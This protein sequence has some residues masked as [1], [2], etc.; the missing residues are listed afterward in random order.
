[1]SIA[2]EGL[3]ELRWTHRSG[4]A[5]VVAGGIRLTAA[6]GT[7]WSNDAAGDGNPVDNLSTSLSFEPGAGDFQFSARVEVRAPRTTF[8]AAVL[9]VWADDRHWAKLCFEQSPQQE[10]MVVSVVTDGFSD[11]ANGAPI[12]GDAVWLR[13]SRIGAAFAFHYSLDGS[14]W[15][16]ARLFRL[17]LTHDPLVGL[18]AQAPHGDR[19]VTTFTHVSFDRR[20]LHDLR[21][22]D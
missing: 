5:E 7:D 18:M 13:I 14:V 19:A 6:A 10:A 11:D 16:F 21:A 20:T 4:V 8:D 9:T 12:E 2:V 17:D 15:R 22:G 1:M 3:P